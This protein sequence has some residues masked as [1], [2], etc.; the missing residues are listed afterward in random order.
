VTLAWY[1]EPI[2]YL[3]VTRLGIGHLT[4]IYAR[5]GLLYLLL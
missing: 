1:R 2:L 3:R 5:I 4:S